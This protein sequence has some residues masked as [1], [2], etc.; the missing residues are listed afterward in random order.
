MSRVK[1]DQMFCAAVDASMT[2]ASCG[3]VRTVNTHCVVGVVHCM[4]LC[5]CRLV[6]CDCMNVTV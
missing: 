5:A 2:L 1:G 6:F 3:G 4:S